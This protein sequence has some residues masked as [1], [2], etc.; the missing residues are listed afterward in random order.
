M[1]RRGALLCT[2][3]STVLAM[4]LAVAGGGPATSGPVAAPTPPPAAAGADSAVTAASINKAGEARLEA[5]REAR[6]DSLGN[7]R[8]HLAQAPVAEPAPVAPA[9]PSAPAPSTGPGP[10][11]EP[12]PSGAQPAAVPTCPPPV[13]GAV[14][15]APSR[16]SAGGVAGTSSA[17]LAAFAAAYNAIRVAQ[18]LPPVPPANFRHD[19]CME[20]RLFWMAEDPSTD[21]M[22]AWGHLGSVRSDGVPSVGCDGN[23]AGGSGNTG[24]TVAQKWWDS[25]S[26]RAS[27]YRPADTGSTAAVCVYFAMTHGGIPNE[28]ASFTRAAARWAGC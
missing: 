5:E 22:S 15:G 13:A 10:N 2:V 20:D 25:G 7:E 18:C 11:T 21:P 16:V 8:E 26:H 17:D 3:F 12:A 23:L 28:P 4:T 19:S 27:L 6:R 14:G 24:A 9:P 1:R